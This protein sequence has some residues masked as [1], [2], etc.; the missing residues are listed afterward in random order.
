MAQTEILS[1]AHPAMD[2]DAHEKSYRMFLR[3]IQYSAAGAAFILIVLAF[4]WG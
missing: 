2:Y 4:L 1:E 3:L